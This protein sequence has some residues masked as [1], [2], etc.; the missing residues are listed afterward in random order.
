[1]HKALTYTLLY[2]IPL[3]IMAYG[4]WKNIFAFIM[5]ASWIVSSFIIF[6]IPKED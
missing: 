3:A 6:N 4:L 2:G 5:G 1:M